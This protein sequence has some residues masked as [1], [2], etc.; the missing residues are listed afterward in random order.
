MHIGSLF[1]D[2]FASG[3]LKRLAVIN[4]TSLERCQQGGSEIG[5]GKSLVAKPRIAF[6]LFPGIRLTH[7]R[8]GCVESVLRN[9]ITVPTSGIKRSRRIT[10]VV[11]GKSIRCSLTRPELLAKNAMAFTSAVALSELR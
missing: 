5:A 2:E 6:V 4:L 7:P 10:I 8:G 1:R 3:N 11:T 9:R